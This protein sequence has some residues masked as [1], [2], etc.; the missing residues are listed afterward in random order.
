MADVGD[1]RDSKGAA[2][3]QERLEPLCDECMVLYGVA[4]PEFENGTALSALGGS[5]F[6]HHITTVNRGRAERHAICPGTDKEV[7]MFTSANGNAKTGYYTSAKDKIDV[8]TEFM[9]YRPEARNVYLVIDYEYLKVKK[10]EP[11]AIAGI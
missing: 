6:N 4:I 10:V 2:G 8:V 1:P 7:E 5:I 9:N 11:R 3:F